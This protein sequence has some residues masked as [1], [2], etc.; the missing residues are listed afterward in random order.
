MGMKQHPPRQILE[1]KLV[2]KNVIILKIG[3]PPPPPPYPDIFAKI[4]ANSPWIFYPRASMFEIMTTETFGRTMLKSTTFERKPRL[5]NFR[6]E[7][8]ALRYVR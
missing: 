6:K 1:K 7:K 5:F 8:T 4:W 2:N 3:D